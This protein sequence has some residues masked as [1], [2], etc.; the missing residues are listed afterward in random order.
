MSK[1]IVQKLYKDPQ[2]FLY[3][4]H[5]FAYL[6]DLEEKQQ[7]SSLPRNLYVYCVLSTLFSEV[8]NGGFS[9]YLYN[10][11]RNTF[12][13]L[14][15]CAKALDVAELTDL[16]LDFVNTITLAMK[17]QKQT[18][19]DYETDEETENILEAF[20]NRF[21]ELD[22]R[23]QF[24]ET[25]L[26]FYKNNFTVNSISFAAVKEKPSDH[27]RY[28]VIPREDCCTDAAEATSCFLKVLADFSALRWRIE[29]WNF[30]DAYRIIA[31]ADGKAVPLETIMKNWGDASYAFSKESNGSY[32]NRMKIASYFGKTSVCCG[33]DGISLYVVEITPSGF[34][35][36]EM[37]MVHRFAS[38]GAPYDQNVF[39]IS[40]G[41]MSHKKEPNK[42]DVIK[43][44]LFS[45][46]KEHKNIETVFE[47]GSNH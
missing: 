24:D 28:F 35:Q 40:I 18:L 3:E 10:A 25:L 34:E 44:C 14:T 38:A 33:T 7:L 13:D 37:K 21:Y 11:S 47:S 19:S 16:V 29:L 45:H 42:Y 27:C 30:F 36:N 46:F 12:Y 6:Q 43:N 8:N 22:Q 1:V 39:K 20:D 17:Q 15:Q 2:T 32:E 41:D 4:E 5:F 26:K 23:F 31:H 9:Q